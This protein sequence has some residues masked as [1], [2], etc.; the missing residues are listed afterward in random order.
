M[1][2]DRGDAAEAD[3]DGGGRIAVAMELRNYGL[4]ESSCIA[5][6]TRKYG[7]MDIRN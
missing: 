3:E 2:E 4:T 7:A 1:S 6:D 5:A